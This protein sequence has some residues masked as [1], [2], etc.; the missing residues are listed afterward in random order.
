MVDCLFNCIEKVVYFHFDVIVKLVIKPIYG[1]GKNIVGGV[2]DTTK[3]VAN[4]VYNDAKSVVNTIG[5]FGD[6]VVNTGT[7]LVDGLANALKGIGDILNP[8]TIMMIIGG[9]VVISLINKS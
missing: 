1:E 9:V 2:V 6:K 8:T 3:D 5:K 7:D 4:T